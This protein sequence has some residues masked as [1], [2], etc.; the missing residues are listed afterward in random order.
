MILEANDDSQKHCSPGCKAKYMGYGTWCLCVCLCVCKN[1]CFSK[2]SL[3]NLTNVNSPQ[4]DLGGQFLADR[5]AFVWQRVQSTHNAASEAEGHKE[6]TFFCLLFGYVYLNGL[7]MPKTNRQLIVCMLLFFCYIGIL[8]R[9][10][11]VRTVKKCCSVPVKVLLEK[12]LLQ[13][14]VLKALDTLSYS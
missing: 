9:L 2:Q 5:Q 10:W 8:T 6:K 7:Y 4:F 13:V 1:H 3:Q 11:N 14:H 12:M